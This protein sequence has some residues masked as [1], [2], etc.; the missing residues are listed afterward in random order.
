LS[1]KNN[2]LILHNQSTTVLLYI[3][4]IEYNLSIHLVYGT[5]SEARNRHEF[6][7]FKG[8]MS[9]AISRSRIIS[10]A[11]TVAVAVVGFAACEA[12]APQHHTSIV[13]AT[14]RSHDD[15]LVSRNAMFG[16]FGT[17]EKTTASAAGTV[18]AT[19]SSVFD[20]F[21]SSSKTKSNALIEKTKDIVDNKSGFYSS[22]DASVFA[23]DF[24][25][26]GS[27]VGP[28]NKKDYL[29]T[30]KAF[31]IHKS[32]PDINANSW[33]YSIDPEDPNRVWFMV[34][35]TGT[36]SGDPMLPDLAN[37]QPNG[38]ELQGCPETFSVLYDEE[39]KVKYLTVG[40]VADRF[41]GNTKGQG[42]AFGIFNIMGLPLP[43][44]GPFLQFVQWFGS[45]VVGSY[46][47]S[48]STDV[49]AWFLEE[50]GR[51]KASQGF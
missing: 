34:R 19:K 26:R 13:A 47:L 42:A 3:I 15:S 6:H 2:I 50:K 5:V 37:I 20:A 51:E 23:E 43:A 30:M 45:E 22:Y 29:G 7:N 44:P 1:Q 38:Q 14:S 41:D 46:P 48:Y 27:L 35:N 12:F 25:F 36:F 28:L 40:Y 10:I 17:E 8:I 18:T 24:V 4:T 16:L 31:S 9:S 11:V 32:I 39:E 33:G 49:P 21:S